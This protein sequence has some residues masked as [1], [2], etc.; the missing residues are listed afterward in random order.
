LTT[1][2]Y[3]SNEDFAEYL[4]NIE[5]VVEFIGPAT[6]TLPAPWTKFLLHGVPTCMDV[7][8]SVLIPK[9]LF[10]GVLLD[11]PLAGSQ[12]MKNVQEKSF[13]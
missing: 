8:T 1:G 10:L 6:V 4:S 5:K 12:M 11:K 9:R 3:D 13:L 7:E 2:L